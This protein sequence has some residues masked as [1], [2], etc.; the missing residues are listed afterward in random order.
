MSSLS[1]VRPPL[2]FTA[3]LAARRGGARLREN[4]IALAVGALACFYGSNFK[5]SILFWQSFR[6]TGLPAMKVVIVANP[7]IVM[8]PS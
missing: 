1:S 6:V 7:N 8:I 2:T 4:A 3:A 5:Y